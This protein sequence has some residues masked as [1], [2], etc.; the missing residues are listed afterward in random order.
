LAGGRAKRRG[1]TASL[2]A[3][4]SPQNLYRDFPDNQSFALPVR[5]IEFEE[6][7]GEKIYDDLKF[8]K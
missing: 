1:A 6:L 4:H 7:V 5:V 3:R 2:T 8:K